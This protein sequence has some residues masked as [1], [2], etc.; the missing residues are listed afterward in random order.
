M[1]NSEAVAAAELTKIYCSGMVKP[2]KKEIKD[3]YTDMRQ[4]VRRQEL[5]ARNIRV[6]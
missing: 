2:S 4:H 1:I 3:I 5:E 6:E